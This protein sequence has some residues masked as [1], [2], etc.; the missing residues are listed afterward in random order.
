MGDDRGAGASPGRPVPDGGEW[1][2]ESEDDD[3]LDAG[4]DPSGDAAEAGDASGDAATADEQG[5]TDE[6]FRRLVEQLQEGDN[7]SIDEDALATAREASSS[8]DARDVDDTL[9]G[10]AEDDESE[11][12]PAAD[13]GLKVG[14]LTVPPAIYVLFLGPT[15]V[16]A[17]SP[18]PHEFLMPTGRL[19]RAL[20]LNA[21]LIVPVALLAGLLY[22][23]QRRERYEEYR[24]DLAAGVSGAP[25][26][27]L[28]SVFLLQILQIP[29]GNLLVGNLGAGLGAVALIVV[30]VVILFVSR[31]GLYALMVA[32]GILLLLPAGIGVYVGTFV[33]RVSTPTAE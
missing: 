27:I 12:G 29:V 1:P 7:V 5:E 6:A 18:I 30:G 19:P 13:F 4:E 31:L 25:T 9:A 22:G 20:L 21:G 2:F 24:L 8:G 16:L 32:Y 10:D 3:A 14:L 33:G 17:P 15:A 28:A 23:M 11:T 26:A